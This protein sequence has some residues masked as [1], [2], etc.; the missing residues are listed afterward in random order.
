M[1]LSDS[2]SFHRV[3][4]WFLYTSMILQRGFKKEKEKRKRTLKSN[5]W[6]Q[7]QRMGYVYSTYS[8]VFFFTCCYFTVEVLP[9]C[10]ILNVRARTIRYDTPCIFQSLRI[11]YCFP[12]QRFPPR[13]AANMSLC[14]FGMT[15]N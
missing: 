13:S 9:R 11:I 8:A 3:L 1:R 2:V 15:D 4:R 14:Q 7:S 10:G 5:F 12:Q 6:P